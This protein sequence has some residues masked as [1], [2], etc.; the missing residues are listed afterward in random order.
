MSG[1]ISL[2]EACLAAVAARLASQLPSAAVE[3]AR[4]SPPD[5]ENEGLPRLIVRGDGI[6]DDTESDPT[7]THYSILFVVHGYARGASDLAAEQAL[8]S[9]Y[10]QVI[11]ALD[12][13][14]PTDPGLGDVMGQGTEFRLFDTDESAVPAG[15]FVARFSML[16]VGPAGGPW[17]S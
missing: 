4:R 6:D 5:L 3:R 13:W 1:T 16:A 10:A 17:S 11:T 14:T 12:R 15:E 7:R 2:R 9:L 8:S